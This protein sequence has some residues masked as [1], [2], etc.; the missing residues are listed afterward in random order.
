MTK[1]KTDASDKAREW[2]QGAVMKRAAK[3]VCAGKKVPEIRATE[4]PDFL[5]AYAAECVRLEREQCAEIARGE[6]YG[7]QRY[8]LKLKDGTRVGGEDLL[9]FNKAVCEVGEA[10]AA[11]IEGRE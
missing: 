1:S 6:G 4:I 8:Y 9:A 7:S 5:A 10:I 2:F 11:A 3:L